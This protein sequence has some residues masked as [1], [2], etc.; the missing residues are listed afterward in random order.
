R[1]VLAY[2]DVATLGQPEMFIK[3]DA[4]RINENGEIVNDDT[5]K[6]LQAFVDRYADWVKRQL[7]R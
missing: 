4:S 5:R 3:H 2:L 1:N 7:G 6:F